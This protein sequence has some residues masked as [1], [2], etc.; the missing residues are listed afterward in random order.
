MFH[1]T[2]RLLI[3]RCASS[4]QRDAQLAAFKTGIQALLLRCPILGGDVTPLPPDVA[5]ADKQDWRT[6]VPGRGV[7]LVVRDLRGKMPPFQELEAANFPPLQLPWDLL[8]PI[9]RDLSNDHP[10]AACKMQ[11]S[12]IEGGTVL[13][14]ATSH[15]VTDGAGT[16]QWMRILSD[17]MRLAQDDSIERSAAEIVGLDRSVLSNMTS[18]LEFDIE[19]HPAYRFKRPPPP[20]DA[21]ASEPAPTNVFGATTSEVP[22]LLRLSPTG[23]AQLKV[24]ATIP[25]APPISTHDALCA[26]M[27]RTVL[28]IRSRRSS[29]PSLPLSATSNL[30]MPS[31]ARRHLPALPSSYVGNATYQIIAPLNLGT[32][33]SP[34][35]LPRAAGSVRRAVKAYQ[36]MNGTTNTTGFAMGTFLGSGE[37]M[38]GGDWGEAFGP[39]VR[40]RV[41]G[42]PGNTVLPRRPDGSIEAI[43]AVRPEEVE[44]LTGVEGF[45]KYLV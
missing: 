28:L 45:G 40:F 38:Y 10:H 23:L 8:M 29:A 5:M 12:A 1:F 31:D 21:P 11:F 36:F 42:E 2:R 32:L 18:N 17:G 43:V 34:S 44:V 30:F 16:D 9:P 3:F 19:D 22:V 27:W 41:I 4:A 7:E 20:P 37:A 13:T 15:C 6:I 26:L 39:L 14:F 24:D 35:G 25:S 33:L